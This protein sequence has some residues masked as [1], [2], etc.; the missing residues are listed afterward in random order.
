[1]SI[2]QIL[3][4]R[5]LELG[6]TLEDI[7]KKIGTSKQTIQRYEAGIISN[8][9]SDKIEAL[10]KVLQITPAYLM[11]WENTPAI[12]NTPKN[13]ITLTPDTSP[14]NQTML[15]FNKN[16]IKGGYEK[17]IP[18]DDVLNEINKLVQ[19]LKIYPAEQINAL[20][21]IVENGGNIPIKADMSQEMKELITASSNLS[22][23]NIKILT[24]VA[25]TMK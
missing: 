23:E 11:G 10:A 12:D 22:P 20:L 16:G 3:K 15:I 8:I 6:Y 21:K 1:M 24:K 4:N 2:G 19:V 5:R 14:H 9:P 17:T 18:S 13:Y 7:A 25:K